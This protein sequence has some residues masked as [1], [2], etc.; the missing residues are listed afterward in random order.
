MKKI[1]CLSALALMVFITLIPP[2]SAFANSHT[3]YSTLS[4]KALAY[5]DIDVAPEEWK[6][7]ILAARNLVI[8]SHSWTVNGQVSY[9]LP[10]GTVKQLPEFSDLFPDWD[11]PKSNTIK[12]EISQKIVDDPIFTIMAANYAGFVYLRN[13]P[14]GAETPVFYGFRS[15][16]N[17][18]SM[19][20]DSLAGSSY[21]AGYS[22]LTDGYDVGWAN[23]LPAG[24]KFY[25]TNPI[26][27][28][29]YGARAS[30][31]STEGYALMGVVDDP[32]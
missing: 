4:S 29:D 23:Y 30:T 26:S 18:V 7:S 16:A 14:T 12:N 2:N 28:H 11:V 19:T 9:E 21:N 31:F 15:S 5:S 17:R 20:A 6:K 25:L 1:A 8:Y 22:D 27:N 10:D 24:S 3:N 32:R 13:P